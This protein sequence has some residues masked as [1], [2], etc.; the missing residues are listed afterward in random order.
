MIVRVRVRFRVRVHPNLAFLL[1]F[2]R[3]FFEKNFLGSRFVDPNYD[4][5]K[6]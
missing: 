1:A 2:F 4:K 5:T 6:D 3:P